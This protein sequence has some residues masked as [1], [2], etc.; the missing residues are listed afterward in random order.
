[1]KCQD[2][3]IWIQGLMYH[4]GVI[5]RIPLLAIW[6]R[7]ML[8]KSAGRRYWKTTIKSWMAGKISWFMQTTI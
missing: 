7:I 4:L 3:L 1:M 6:D 8:V 5:L 2:G